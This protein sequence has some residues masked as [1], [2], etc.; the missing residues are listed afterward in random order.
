MSFYDVDVH[1]WTAE[2]AALLRDGHTEHADLPAI[3]E[4]LDDM[5]K[6]ALRALQSHMRVLLAHLLKYQY[7]PERRTRS[8]KTTIAEQRAQ[9]AEDL[10]ESPSLKPKL[11]EIV[12]Y[13]WSLALMQ[14]ATET[15]L[16]ERSFPEQCPYTLDQILD[17]KF[18][19]ET[20]MEA[21]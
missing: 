13:S 6:T 2:Q 8:W 18:L 20:E 10:N 5:S 15:D 1:A 3:A 4:A 16:P 7:Q 17:F 21:G 19:P 12:K 9:I 14:A 11:N